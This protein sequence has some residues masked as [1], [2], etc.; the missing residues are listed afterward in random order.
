M[1]MKKIFGIAV[2]LLS[3]TTACHTPFELVQI[4]RPSTSIYP[5]AQVEPSI[6]INP[7]NPSKMIVGTVMDDYHYSVDGGKTWDA[8]TLTS[9]YGVNGDPVMLIDPHE[10]YYF[11][12]LANP[13]D[14]A[15]LDRIVC[16]KSDKIEGSF[17]EGTFPLPN[18]KVQD[19]QW[20]DYDEK[21][22]AIYMTW[23]Q[24]DAYKSEIPSDSSI[25][26]F[27][28]SL[29]RGDTWSIPKRISFYAG[30]CM[31]GNETVEGATP[32][33]GPNG[34][35]Y[36]TWTGP[37]GIMFNKS[38][39]GGETWMQQESKVI[40]HPGGWSISIPGIMRCNGLP[41]IRCDRSDSEHR[42]T[43]YI[44]WA[45]QKNGIDD[46]DI[47]LIKSTDQGETWSEPIRV[48]DDKPGRH[49]F[50]TWMTIDQST[51]VIYTVFYD[52][53][54]HNDLG[55]DVYLAYSRDGGLTF[56][57]QKISKKPF[58]PSASYFFG[59][60]TNIAAVNGVVRPV[61]P[62]MDKGKISLWIAL[63][64]DVDLK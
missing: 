39:D 45:D 29:D 53:R 46:T 35:L 40:D 60:Y 50:F 15:Y 32:V 44:N 51:G 12:H 43:I 2:V 58:Y 47:W 18:G 8:F 57:N 20:V 25:I 17:D 24:F 6:A 62:Q 19:K 5:M 48:N 27:S 30:D 13:E 36:V 63:I 26:V 61:W 41:I 3:V 11:F 22:D 56:R 59:D 38:F 23:T 1:K 52:R 21:N 49:Q 64:S 16:Q 54:N 10:R 7:V 31:D 37:Q 4:Q 42:G 33:V 34:E 9:K 55:T 28:K 14:G